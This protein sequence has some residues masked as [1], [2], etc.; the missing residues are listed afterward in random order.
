MQSVLNHRIIERG[1]V[2]LKVIGILLIV[3]GVIGVLLGSMMFGD[4]GI[5]A[6]IGA[7]SAILSG[8]GFVLADK[9][10][11]LLIAERGNV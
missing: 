2:K 9:K 5:A 6:M 3:L 4:I 8:V 7:G 1:C 10:I 11:N